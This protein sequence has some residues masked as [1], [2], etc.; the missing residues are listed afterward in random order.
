[1]MYQEIK[2]GKQ[3]G[4]HFELQK[5]MGAKKY[6]ISKLSFDPNNSWDDRGVFVNYKKVDGEE[7]TQNQTIAFDIDETILAALDSGV[8]FRQEKLES[9]E[10]P[11][12]WVGGEVEKIKNA[13]ENAVAMGFKI[14]LI[15]HRTFTDE[16]GLQNPSARVLNIL[17]YIDPDKRNV[18]GIFF[19]A[20]GSKADIFSLLQRI[21]IKSCHRRTN[22]CCC[23]RQK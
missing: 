12:I 1:M 11:I 10:D 19:A 18:T 6:K 8:K 3:S 5:A 21:R 17:R 22:C 4:Y 23:Q 20:S 9:N 2:E 7:K 16:C 15:T 14:V 13:I